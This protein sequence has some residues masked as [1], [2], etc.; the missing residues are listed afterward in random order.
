MPAVLFV[1]KIRLDFS[2]N[3]WMMGHI[4]IKKTRRNPLLRLNLHS[5]DF[6]HNICTRPV[7]LNLFLLNKNF[8]SLDLLGNPWLQLQ[9]ISE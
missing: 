2:A 5:I 4:P 3:D 7:A 6:V 9:E 1:Y 8:F